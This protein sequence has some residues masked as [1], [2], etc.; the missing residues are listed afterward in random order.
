[1]NLGN[2]GANSINQGIGSVFRTLAAAPVARQQAEDQAALN[3]ARIFAQNMSGQKHGA[4]AEGL[5]MTN[6]NRRNI[7]NIIAQQPDMLPAVQQMYRN[8]GLGGDTNTER[9]A[10]AAGAFQKQQAITDIQGGADP[11]RTGQAYAAVSGK[12]PFSAV[13]STGRSINGLTG[14]GNILESALAGNYDAKIQSEVREN[15]AQAGAAGA[16]AGL[17]NER[18]KEIQMGKIAPGA[19]ELGNPILFRSG[20]DG[21]VTVLDDLTPFRKSGGADAAWQKARARVVEQVFK[22]VNV[23]PEDREAEIEARM[24]LIGGGVKSAA[25]ASPSVTMKPSLPAG[26]PQGSKQIGT[27]NGKPVYQAPNGKRYIEG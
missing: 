24:A 2:N 3:A 20:T 6:D 27:S 19:D 23:A 15:N 22:D 21:K 10:N 4:E 18:R 7:E 25:P 11:T 16:S 12:M 13:A 5:Q 17:S 8:F 1:M 14:L 9:M 26:I